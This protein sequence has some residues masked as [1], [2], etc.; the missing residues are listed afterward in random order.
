MRDISA[1]ILAHPPL[2]PK[3][4]ILYYEAFWAK[5]VGVTLKRLAEDLQGNLPSFFEQSIPQA[6]K[7]EIQD[8]LKNVEFDKLNVLI[9]GMADYPQKLQP[10][11]IPLLY[12]VGDIGLIESR[13]V[14]IVGARKATERG[15]HAARVMA[16][17]LSQVDI[18]VV[19]GL[20]AGIDTAAHRETIQAGG[21]TI[22]V[23]GTP[24][25]HVYPREN[26]GLQEEIARKHLLISHIPFFKYSQQDYRSN[27]GFFPERNKVMAALSEATIIAE[28]SDTSGSLIQAREAMRLGKKVII[29]KPSYDNPKL[30]WPKTYHKRGAY[31]AETATEVKQILGV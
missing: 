5:T 12:F 15:L 7:D 9:Q 4:E 22:G 14:S 18:T 27:R 19:S 20:A 10:L 29:L 2:I 11:G 13:S 24:I 23:I 31:V 17:S 21:K 16:N 30:T 26:V 8:F 1:S 25:N 3:H 28:A 6:L